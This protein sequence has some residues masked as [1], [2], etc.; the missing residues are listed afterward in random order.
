M[1]E[2]KV[3]IL[4]ATFS[5]FWCPAAMHQCHMNQEIFWIPKQIYC[6]QNQVKAAMFLSESNV[7]L[8]CTLYVL[9]TDLL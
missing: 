6:Y 2:T 8:I 1:G 5:Q 9:S 4:A 7:F 3:C